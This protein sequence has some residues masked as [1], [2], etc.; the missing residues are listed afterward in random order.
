[1]F[2]LFSDI[3]ACRDNALVRM[4]ARAK[5][6]VAFVTIILIILSTQGGLPL[7]VLIGCLGGMFALRLPIRLV[8]G[9][10]A[11]PMGV[12]LVLVVL[13]SFTYGSSPLFAVSLGPWHGMVKSDGLVHG[14]LIGLRVLGSV[15][16]MVLLSSV[17][18]AHKIFQALRWFRVSKAWVEIAMLMYR[19]TFALLD[20]TEDVAAAQKMRLG[21]AGVKR[22]LTSMG[23]LVGAVVVQSLDQSGRTH[24]AMTLRG[25]NGVMPYGP[26]PIM[27]KCDR[28][29]MAIALCGVGLIFL[30]SEWRNF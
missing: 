3:F 20:L 22:S 30:L 29:I 14:L 4:D 27:R 24:Q 17:T 19:Y 6:V 9:R 21:Y 15:S 7:A 10:L 12:V 2:H 11:A 8:L 18:P 16:V 5:L 1:M 28:C 25:Y 23:V 13:Q 26:L